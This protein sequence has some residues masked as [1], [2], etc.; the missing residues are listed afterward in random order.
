MAEP[1][2]GIMPPARVIHHLHGADAPT[3][4]EARTWIGQRVVDSVGRGIGRLDD[5][6]VDAESGA[7]A[8]L[9]LRWGRFNGRLNLIPFDGATTG[10]DQVWVPF[11]RD[12]VRSSPEIGSREILTGS[13]GRKLR[14]HYR[15]APL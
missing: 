15:Q 1:V 13:L 7:P 8:W 10:A 2:A 12:L 4:G 9:L 5:V 11:D 3:L 14:S 6:W